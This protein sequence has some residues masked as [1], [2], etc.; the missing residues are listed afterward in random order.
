MADFL[1]TNGSDNA[2]TDFVGGFG[3]DELNALGGADTLDGGPGGL[4]TL[5]GGSG[6]DTYIIGGP[7]EADDVIQ[8][9][10][11]FRDSTD[12]GLSGGT[13]TVISSR[14]YTL[15]ANL[16]NLT[17]EGTATTGIGNSLDNTIIGNDLDNN[18]QGAGGNDNLLGGLGSDI[19]DGGAGNNTLSGGA[20]DDTYI[21][22]G[23]DTINEGAGDGEDTV[24]SSASYTLANNLENLTLTGTAASTL[25]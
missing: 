7:D 3:S 19:L 4:D 22:D 14:N 8:E 15:G 24:L 11:N 23:N 13:D 21:T 10:E 9:F 25:R 5:R 2:A 17:L 6:N 20:D 16:E 1:G 18:L 12:T